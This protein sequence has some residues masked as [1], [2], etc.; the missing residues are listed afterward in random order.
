LW[1]SP[2]GRALENLRKLEVDPASAV[3]SIKRAFEG[4]RKRGTE[5]QLVGAPR[6]VLESIESFLPEPALESPRP[7]E[8]VMDIDDGGYCPL[9]LQGEEKA[10]VV[11]R[12]GCGN[13]CTFC[14]TRIIN[15]ENRAPWFIDPVSKV[16]RTLEDVR[17]RGYR[18][19]RFAAIEPLE[20]P[21]I[22]TILRKC[23]DLGFD[24]VELWSHAGPLADMDFTRAVVNAGLTALDVPVFGPDAVVH[25]AIAGRPGAFAKTLQGLQNLRGLGFERIS[26]HMV[27][28]R[29]NHT[30]VAET[31][32]ACQQNAFGPV[33]R[34][35]LAAPSSPDPEKFRPVAAPLFELTD[36]LA[37]AQD[38]LPEI[39]LK[40]ALSELAE[41]MPTCVLMGR[42]PDAQWI[43]QRDR[44][45]AH[46]YDAVRVKDYSKGL[47]GEGRETRGFDLKQ[48]S[49]CPKRQD[50]GLNRACPGVFELYLKLYGEGELTPLR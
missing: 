12:T 14:T 7:D 44:A 31:L 6:S 23:R 37:G 26:A 47:D 5:I 15:L 45:A 27:V 34:I 8:A 20:H 29:G 4:A 33:E 2:A 46:P 18:S 50:C 39:L 25:D 3:P 48:R 38:R 10:S 19:L 35:V 36:A 21:D 43:T 22:L 28:A 32:A 1:L 30:R 41:N 42:F 24:P 17:S 9:D 49:P 16:L 13:N 40:K 11:I